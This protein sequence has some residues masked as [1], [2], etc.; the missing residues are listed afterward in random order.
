M[1]IH[2]IADIYDS[3]KRDEFKIGYD[4]G[5]LDAYYDIRDFFFKYINAWEA[6]YFDKLYSKFDG[7]QK[8]IS[9]RQSDFFKMAIDST[10]DIREIMQKEL[11]KR[12]KDTRKDLKQYINF[13]GESNGETSK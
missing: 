1:A 10:V 11:D 13:K 8:P 12:Y 2:Q 9:I 3:S 4:Y 6:E 7:L 5:K